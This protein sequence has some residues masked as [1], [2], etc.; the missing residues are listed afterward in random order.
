MTTSKRF[1]AALG[2]A[3]AVAAAGAAQAEV[4]QSAADAFLVEH[5]AELRAAPAELYAAIGRVGQ[6]WSPPHTWSGD[7]A[8]LSLEL[9]AGGCF[10]ERWSGGEA[11]HLRVGQVQG[12]RLVRL[13]GGLGPLQALGLQGVLEFRIEPAAAGSSLVLSYR[14]SGDSLH[15]LGELAPVVDAVL[16]E[17]F[18]RLSRF[19]ETGSPDPAGNDEG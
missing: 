14:V 16:A 13:L 10:C 3:A 12:D 1:L 5:R 8:N 11:E 2:A 19:A 9:R 18:A 17:Q 4:K 15:Q 6:W 7:P